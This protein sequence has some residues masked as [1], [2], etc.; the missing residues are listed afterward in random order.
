MDILRENKIETVISL[1]NLRESFAFMSE[2]MPGF[3][4]TPNM[5]RDALE[6]HLSQYFD[7]KISND[8]SETFTLLQR[9]Y[10]DEV[11]QILSQI[12]AKKNPEILTGTE[13]A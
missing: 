12:A 6:N 10:P 3:M 4:N 9:E 5:K 7:I 8:S 2:F 1:N 11:K 13:L